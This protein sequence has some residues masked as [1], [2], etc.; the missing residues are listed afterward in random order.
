VPTSPPTVAN[1]GPKFGLGPQA[2]AARFRSRKD[3]GAALSFIRADL[4]W[5]KQGEQSGQILLSLQACSVVK[6]VL[7]TRCDERLCPVLFSGLGHD[8]IF[9][10]TK[11]AAVHSDNLCDERLCPVDESPQ[12]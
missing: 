12:L 11:S 3:A 6:A 9:V 7:D 5:S 8:L 10:S 2:D 1:W 4:K